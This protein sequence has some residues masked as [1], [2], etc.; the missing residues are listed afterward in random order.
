[1]RKQVSVIK[2]NKRILLNMK[3]YWQSVLVATVLLF[4]GEGLIAQNKGIF[5]VKSGT[6]LKFYCNWMSL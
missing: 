3:F 1:M 2:C 4:P 6:F 5:G